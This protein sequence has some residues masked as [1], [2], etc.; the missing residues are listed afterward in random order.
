MMTSINLMAI[1]MNILKLIGVLFSPVVFGLAFL[2]PL[3][4]EIILL[5]NVT[6][7]FGDP[8]IW[9]VVIGGILGGIAQWR[10]S[11]IWVKPV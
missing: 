6:V 9:G 11:W 3:L 4:S 5:L 1:S 7:P 2:G 10:G 8:L